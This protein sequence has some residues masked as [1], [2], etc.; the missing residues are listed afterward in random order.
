MYVIS[1]PLFIDVPVTYF[2]AVSYAICVFDTS[3]LSC[4]TTVL[5]P[6]PSFVVL[7]FVILYPGIVRGAT[8]IPDITG[9]FLSGTFL[10]T[11]LALAS[12]SPGR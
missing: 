4:K 12:S 2:E 5:P 7:T 11:G 8:D 1:T 3:K 10:N 6:S 9:T